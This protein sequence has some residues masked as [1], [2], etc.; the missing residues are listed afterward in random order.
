MN[1]P[2]DRRH[3]YCSTRRRKC[4]RLKLMKSYNKF[5]LTIIPLLGYFMNKLTRITRFYSIW[6]ENVF[7][8]TWNCIIVVVV[9][10][11]AERRIRERGCMFEIIVHI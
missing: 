5:V 2:P 9:K 4:I 6:N 1:A 10:M 3:M 7:D 11:F 8:V